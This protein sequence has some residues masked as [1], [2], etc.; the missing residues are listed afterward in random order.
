MALLAGVDQLPEGANVRRPVLVAGH[1]SRVGALVH[2]E[3]DVS[4]E[5][6]IEP[7]LKKSKY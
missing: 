4:N 1:N 3:V 7:L 6:V 5:G 2:F